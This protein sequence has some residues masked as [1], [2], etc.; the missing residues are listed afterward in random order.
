MLNV[1]LLVADMR[2]TETDA[3]TEMQISQDLIKNICNLFFR[4]E[5]R[6]EV[7]HKSERRCITSQRGGVSQIR[8]EVYQR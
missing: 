2:F 8:E 7:Y 1:L 4:L 5:I 3:I 6:E